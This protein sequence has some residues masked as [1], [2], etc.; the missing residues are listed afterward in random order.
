MIPAILR[1]L[2]L[3][4]VARRF[5]DG[6]TSSDPWMNVARLFF[7]C[8]LA[9][10]SYFVYSAATGFLRSHRMSHDETATIRRVETLQSDRAYLQG[11]LAYVA[12]D[13]YVE[14]EARRRLGYVR[15]GEVPVIV[16]APQPAAEPVLGGDWWERLFPR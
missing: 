2:L 1:V 8:C 12:S 10:S 9:V 11:V 15:D 14:Q 3:D 13:A 6:G 7:L 16:H 4:R 5:D